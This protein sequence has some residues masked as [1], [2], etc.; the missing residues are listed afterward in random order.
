MSDPIANVEKVIA[1]TKATIA[2]LEGDEA[3]ATSWV[4]THVAVIIGL[5]AFLLGWSTR[6]IHL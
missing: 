4:K 6:F 3:K 1:D 2:T 5:A